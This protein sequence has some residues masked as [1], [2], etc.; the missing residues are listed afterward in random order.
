MTFHPEILDA[1]FFEKPAESGIHQ[2]GGGNFYIADLTG[3]VSRLEIRTQCF[4]LHR[5]EIKD[6]PAARALRHFEN[7]QAYLVGSPNKGN[8]RNWRRHCLNSTMWSSA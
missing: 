1:G 3:H 5:G 8:D 2:R 7:R 4:R 6:D